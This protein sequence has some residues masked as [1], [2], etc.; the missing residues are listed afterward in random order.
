MF[1]E[2]KEHL[3]HLPKQVSMDGQND[4]QMGR[5]TDEREVIPMYQP[6]YAS[7][8]EIC[9]YSEKECLKILNKHELFHYFSQLTWQ[10][11][12]HK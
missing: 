8:S 7:D 5:Q 10:I 11:A 9:M 12:T 2:N 4:G 1:L 6:V 3:W